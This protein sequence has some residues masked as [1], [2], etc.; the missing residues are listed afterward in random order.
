[1]KPIS[2]HFKGEK[3]IQATFKVILRFADE[4]YGPVVQMVNDQWN[5]LNKDKGVHMSIGTP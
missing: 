3:P 1:L 5:Q 4:C 2:S